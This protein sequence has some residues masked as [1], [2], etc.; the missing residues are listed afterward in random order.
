MKDVLEYVKRIGV[1]AIVLFLVLMMGVTFSRQPLDQILSILT[2]GTQ[3]G[4]FDG[5]EVT[6]EEY[7][8]TLQSC[9]DRFAQFGQVPDF[10]LNGC[11]QNGLQ[12]LYVLPKI[13]SRMG[14]DVTSAEME[15]KL[16]EAAREIAAQ[17]SSTFEDDRMSVRDAYTRLVGMAPVSFRRRATS[18]Q[19][20]QQTIMSVNA[21]PSLVEA[22]TLARETKINLRIIRFTQTS[23]L[24]RFDDRVQ[25]SEQDLQKEYDAWKKEDPSIPPL[26]K[27]KGQ[28]MDRVRTKKKQDL[29]AS[30]KEHL[31]RLKPEEGLGAVSEATGIAAQTAPPVALEALSQVTVPGGPAANLASG[32]FFSDLAKYKPGERRF[33]G[34][35]QDGEATIYLEIQGI[36]KVP[37]SAKDAE[38]MKQEVAARVREQFYRYLVRTESER[39]DFRFHKIEDQAQQ[40]PPQGQ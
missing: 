7:G 17:D 20:A 31:A 27:N 26:D 22:A 38:S 15:K 37:M 8:R 11:L 14:V 4:S 12:E 33:Y 6:Q 10:F 40:A 9:R 24:G 32:D 2:G 36:Q 34:P 29:L 3:Y 18:A 28:V 25:V 1:G 16:V 13:A 23:L 5:E 35:Y 39:G 19:N 21:S 30:A